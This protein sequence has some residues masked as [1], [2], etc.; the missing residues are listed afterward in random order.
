VYWE[1]GR[2]GTAR[3][4]LTQEKIGAAR[5]WRKKE[6]ERPVVRGRESARKGR[7]EGRKQTSLLA[8]GTGGGGTYVAKKKKKRGSLF[9]H[10]AGKRK[11]ED[12][13]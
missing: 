11:E 4:S 1:E 6:R 9:H 13:N 5:C 2:K 10:A 8:A 3:E 7:E 12:E